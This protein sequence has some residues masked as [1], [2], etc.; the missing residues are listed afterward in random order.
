[1]GEYADSSLDYAF[2]ALSDPTRRAILD[3]LSRKDTRVTDMARHFT[4]SLNSVSKHVNVLERAGLVQRT[5][6]GRDHVLSLNAAPMAE[7][8]A[9]MET[10]RAFWDER[11]AALERFALSAEEHSEAIPH[12][13]TSSAPR[14]SE[15]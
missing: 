5:I 6:H 11:L 7:A 14:E 1:M 9:W 3:H 10:Y 12:E 13:G 4:I 15:S 8:A 2:G